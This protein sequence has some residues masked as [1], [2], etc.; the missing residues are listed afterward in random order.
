ME[1]VTKKKILLLILLRR[2]RRLRNSKQNV[3]PKERKSWVRDI[4]K[5]RQEFGDYHQLVQEFRL[6][7]R[8]YFFR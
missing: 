7:D 1:L 3:R 8:E 5:K 6:G 4:F 2:R